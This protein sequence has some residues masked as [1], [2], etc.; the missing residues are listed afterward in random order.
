MLELGALGRVVYCGSAFFPPVSLATVGCF[1]KRSDVATCLWI[2][3]MPDKSQMLMWQSSKGARRKAPGAIKPPLCFPCLPLSPSLP[4]SISR[5]SSLRSFSVSSP[6]DPR[7]HALS[8]FSVSLCHPLFA[9]FFLCFA[10]FSISLSCFF[11]SFSCFLHVFSYPHFF[12]I[13]FLAW[14]TIPVPRS[15]SASASTC[16]QFPAQLA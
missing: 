5:S 10:V 12:L 11:S 8:C 7:S 9:L 2:H 1:Q 15:H 13:D 4:F 16:L 3:W 14:L 6:F